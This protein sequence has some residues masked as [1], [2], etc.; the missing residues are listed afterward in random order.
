MGDE[1]LETTDRV[2]GDILAPGGGIE[3]DVEPATDVEVA[4]EVEPDVD[5]EPDVDSFVEQAASEP[6]VQRPPHEGNPFSD[7]RLTEGDPRASTRVE[8]EAATVEPDE[9]GEQDG[10]GEANDGD[11]QEPGEGSVSGDDGGMGDEPGTSD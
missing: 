11:D 9:D 2:D 1:E 10:G 5:A 7:P 3:P 8:P 4:A 6:A